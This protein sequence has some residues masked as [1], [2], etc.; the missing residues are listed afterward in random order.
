MTDATLTPEQQAAFDEYDRETA[1]WYGSP[2]AGKRDYSAGVL[3]PEVREAIDAARVGAVENVAEHPWLPRPL[4]TDVQAPPD[5]SLWV[6]G[7]H[8]LAYAGARALIVGPSGAIK[9]LICAHASAHV[10]RNGGTVWLFDWETSEG[11]S[12]RRIAEVGLAPED[13]GDRLLY[14]RPSGAVSPD[15]IAAML[16]H[17]GVPTL[18]I[19]DS[20]TSL[21]GAFGADSNS[22][23]GVEI[24]NANVIEP[25]HAAG[26][27]T[28]IIDHVNKNPENQNGATGTPRKRE[29]A[30]VEL[31]VERPGGGLRINVTKRKDRE[32]GIFPEVA[33]GHR[34][35]HFEVILGANRA[36]DFE[37]VPVDIIPEYDDPDRAPHFRPTYL[38]QR[39]SRWLADH[40]GEHTTNAI[41]G[42]VVGNVPQI[43]DALLAL[44]AEGYVKAT[45]GPNRAKLHEHA[46]AFWKS[47]DEAAG[48]TEYRLPTMPERAECDPGA[49]TGATNGTE[50]APAPECDQDRKPLFAGDTSSAT[51]CDQVRPRCDQDPVATGAT[52]AT[53]PLRGGRGPTGDDAEDGPAI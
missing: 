38:M 1:E 44:V 53:T 12:I 32:W 9:S 19:F 52:N 10:I 4:G 51:K 21:I 14:A 26:V 48:G 6:A 33:D 17:L 45:D 37:F 11:G 46:R 30:D 35:G 23:D 43:R 47:H 16:E 2:D 39:V 28:W 5:P 31:Q 15:L 8:G 20:Y 34:I 36:V 40:P 42:A 24:V 27:G 7:G 3:T 18:A 50:D 49:T 41:G 13:R 22:R 25:L 29:L